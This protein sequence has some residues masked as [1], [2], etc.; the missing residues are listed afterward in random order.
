MFFEK[1]NF[2]TPI[3][4][5]WLLKNPEIIPFIQID[6]IPFYSDIP[7]IKK[8]FEEFLID[9]EKHIKEIKIYLN[10]IKII[11]EKEFKEI[12]FK[13]IKLLNNFKNF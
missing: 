5:D 13:K 4:Y 9:R 6:S 1:S 11:K 7:L 10:D 2:F 3:F 12:N 8:N